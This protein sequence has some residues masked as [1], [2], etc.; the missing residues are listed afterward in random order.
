MTLNPC[1]ILVVG[2]AWV[3]DMVMAH[4]LFRMLKS[5]REDLTIT[6]TAP[7]VTAQIAHRMAEID[8]IIETPFRHGRLHLAQC[9][10]VFGD[11]HAGTRIFVVR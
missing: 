5:R 8:E 4:C 1:R 6:L 11:G 10:I 7:P 9:Q 3:G 2:P